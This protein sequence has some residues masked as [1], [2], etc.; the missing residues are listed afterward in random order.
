[1]SLALIEEFLAGDCKEF[2]D[3]A[4]NQAV[5]D[6]FLALVKRI[7]DLPD[8]N[9]RFYEK[10][11]SLYQVTA[12]GHTVDDLAAILMGF[13]GKPAKA[14]GK[15]LPVALRFDPTIKFLGGIRKDQ[16][17]FLKKLKTGAFY[18]ALW[19]WQRDREKIEVL[20][21]FCAPG[22]NAEGYSQLDSL[23]QKYLSRKKIETVSGVGG[24]IHGISLPSFLQMSEMEGATYTLKV[25]SGNRCG[26]LHLEG[27][28][29]IGARYE[30]WTG[31]EAAYRII[32]W[33]NAAIQIEAADP[34]RAKEIHDPLM[35]V[36]MESLKIKD[37]AGAQTP[38]PPPQ[39]KKEP[40][41]APPDTARKR[42]SPPAPPSMNATA[43]KALK[44]QAAPTPAAAD[45]LSG[46]PVEVYF[47]KAVDHSADRQS[48]MPRERKLLIAL[49][50][51]ILFAITVTSGGKLWKKRQI[52][53]RY[54]QLVAD[55]ATTKELDAR[56]V[57]LM[58]YLDAHPRDSHRVELEAQLKDA[59]TAIE[60]QDYEK[61]VADVDN[62]P[63]DDKYEKKAL[64]LY[65]AFLKRYPDS[66]YAR[67]INAAIGGIGPQISEAYF[68]KLKKIASADFMERYAA[69]H[70]YLELFPHSAQRQAVKGM[71]A[72]LASQYAGDL[73]KRADA[74]DARANWD[75][76]IARCDQFLA[77]F[78]DQAAAQSVKRLRSALQDKKDAAALVAEAALAGADYA[79]AKKVYSDYLAK[80]PHTTQKDAIAKHIDELNGKLALKTAWDK[81]AAYA[82]NAANDIFSR[83]RR[84]DRY[85]QA[86]AAGP[87]ATQAKNLRSRLE[88]QLQAAIRA[89]R[90]DEEE[91]QTLA[92]QQAEQA[93]REQKTRRIKNL[94]DQVSR[95][96]RAVANRFADHT[97]GTVTD[98]VTGLTWSLLDSSLEL[99][100]CLSYDEAKEY[101]RQ[102]NTGGHSDWR[103]PT[104]GE[105]A[106][107]YKSKPFFPDTGAPWY[108]SSDSF[109]RGFHLVV[110]VVTSAPETVFKRMFKD[111]DSCGA[112]RAVRG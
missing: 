92:R 19:P 83:I 38:P 50:V 13:F 24:Q 42:Q 78:S 7:D 105:L 73:V 51:V 72:D 62:L 53:R 100:K 36:M 5:L 59:N 61:T 110:D 64:S 63:I 33:D 111:E 99:G 32:S 57:M 9:S 96:L 4:S 56:I 91:K 65:T 75:A 109:S 103:L 1:M 52:N 49:G 34:Q 3:I 10:P 90:V 44:T 106:A 84:L 104:A 87:Y 70:G 112:V 12:K 23:V 14:S 68:E 39:T 98:R 47:E 40:P 25:S 94:R 35:H 81:T 30:T 66:R 15:S 41:A 108:W 95:Q 80:R 102:L 18:G 79:R 29:L 74:C 97:D 22:L 54:D 60:K 21:G 76:C 37:E 45:T 107:L 88:P 48:R 69:Y 82:N 93:G 58:Q 17:F 27:G 67:Q 6:D 8:M 26:Y 89:R 31:N 20:L 16:A 43:A 11:R 101:V 86:H 77:T 28:S 85:L 2:R 46:S 71:I 55:L